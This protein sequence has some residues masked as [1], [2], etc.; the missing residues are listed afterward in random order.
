MRITE[1]KGNNF[2]GKCCK[3]SQSQLLISDLVNSCESSVVGRRCLCVS[4]S[5]KS[6][7]GMLWGYCSGAIVVVLLI[8][9]TELHFQWEH[10]CLCQERQ[11]AWGH[12]LTLRTRCCCSGGLLNVRHEIK[13]IKG[14]WLHKLKGNAQKHKKRNVKYL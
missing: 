12:E 9:V 5:H 13:V 7:F 11:V 14:I 3:W 4:V 10:C 1:G 6:S 8:P 2:S